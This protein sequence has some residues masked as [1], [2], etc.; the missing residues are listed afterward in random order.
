MR[1]VLFLE[2]LLVGGGHRVG[3]YVSIVGELFPRGGIHT[4]IVE[5]ECLLV[6]AAPVILKLAVAPP[7]LE[8]GASGVL[9][10]RVVE[11]PRVVA[12]VHREHLVV[13]VLQAILPPVGE[14]LLTG[15][16]LR[17]L[18]LLLFQF[19]DKLLYH[20]HLLFGGH[21]RQSEQRVLKLD[22]LGVDRE[23]VKHIATTL[24]PRIA[25]IVVGNHRQRLGIARLRFGIESP[26]IIQTAEGQLRH[27]LV[28]ARTGRLLH[29]QLVILNRPGCVSARQVE[30]ADSVINLVKILLVSVIAG[31]TAQRGHL[32]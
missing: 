9:R 28:N 1:V 2:S 31:H 26:V 17:L 21:R 15:G 30:V 24:Q 7:A 32:F 3:R 12:I 11:I 6:A 20:L 23:L 19:V 18:F 16:G 8:L 4:E 14:E 5:T 25:G 27:G 10:G 22:I 29:S 13:L